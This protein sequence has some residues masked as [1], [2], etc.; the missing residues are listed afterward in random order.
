MEM[1]VN[2]VIYAAALKR[3]GWFDKSSALDAAHSSA[4]PI[5]WQMFSS[6]AISLLSFQTV[7]LNNVTSAVDM[8][9]PIP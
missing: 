7:L 3:N 8:T 5:N 6:T 9:N 2:I 4:Y 1:T